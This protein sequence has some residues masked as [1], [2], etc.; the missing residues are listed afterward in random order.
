MKPVD[1]KSNTCNDSSREI[2]DKNPRFRIHDNVRITKY[3]NIFAKGCTPNWSE[4]D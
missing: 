4:E 2:N 1:E 3:K